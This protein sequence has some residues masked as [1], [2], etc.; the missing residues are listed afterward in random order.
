MCRSCAGH[1]QVMC[2]SCAE[3]QVVVVRVDRE[4]QERVRGQRGALR[5]VKGAEMKIPFQF[6]AERTS[7]RPYGARHAALPL[8][9]EAGEWRIRS[10]MA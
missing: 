5:G 2:R 9:W 3:V 7:W 1:V 6:K 8:P 10:D 4:R